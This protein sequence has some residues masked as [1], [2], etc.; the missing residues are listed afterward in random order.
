MPTSVIIHGHFYQ[1]PRENPWL[2]EVEAEPS[3]A[4]YHDWNQR[5]E[6]EC[7]R[8]V[9]AARHLDGEGRITGITNT[10]ARISFNFGPTL[11]EWMERRAP[12]T[13]AAVLEA[14]RKS[15]RET[16]HGNAIAQPYHHAILPLSTRRDKQTEVRWG[17]AD[18]RRR[19]RRDPEGMW[20]PETAVD[21]E[22]LD[23]L[24]QEG[25]RFTILAPH[26]GQPI[27]PA[28]APGLYQTSGG[29]SIALFF[30]DGPI[31]HGVAFGPLIDDAQAWSAH[32]KAEAS[33]RPEGLISIATDG[34]TY[35]H[36]HK[37]AEMA[38]ARLID[39]VDADPALE[40]V[41]CASFLAMSPAHHP[42]Q[43]IE[44]T[45]WSC[46]HGVDRWRAECGCKLDPG[47]PSQQKWRTPL[48]ETFD[49]LAGE[50]HG[51]YEREGGQFFADP[52]QARDAYDPAAG[53]LEPPPAADRGCELLEMER[54]ALRIFTSC[55]WFFDDLAG[56]EPV[57]VLKYAARA[58]ELA[59]AE[60]ARLE[61]GLLERLAAA[62]SNDAEVGT[63]RDLYL[64]R[65]RPPVANGVRVAA[66]LAGLT[67]LQVTTPDPAAY[68]GV[69]SG[70]DARFEVQLRHRRTRSTH[71]YA[72]DTDWGDGRTC[73]FAIRT[74]TDPAGAGDAALTLTIDNLW[75]RHHSAMKHGRLRQLTAVAMSPEFQAGL[76]HGEMTLEQAARLA[77]LETIAAFARQP[78]AEA[79]E[80]AT[81]TVSLLRFLHLHVP[82]DTQ[83][84]LFRV[85]LP[86]DPALADGLLRLRRLM[87][88]A[89]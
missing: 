41:N 71:R 46:A 83:T 80:R 14:D 2:E 62:K 9:V 25:I 63:G 65:V 57:Q 36:H 81:R 24:A 34:E 38:L 72:V 52:W 66:G 32:L 54:N 75:D 48:R 31:S 61:A 86:D 76:A 1:P 50:I 60:A 56:I 87:G 69:V 79:L 12:D 77:L 30:Y 23:V 4:P 43:L 28:G 78:G 16:G 13:Y 88:F 33:H 22:T 17:I 49:W 58:I 51:I 21:D 10:L 47:R 35:G 20:L 15:L 70:R 11:L 53:L 67:E 6:R 5:I 18:F 7:Y 40:L 8:A 37:F 73:T 19:F 84:A 39:L 27:P 29:R 26:Q 85:P 74:L 68:E 59:G 55:A 82:F 89:P 44:P 64:T 42:V 45:S 3:A